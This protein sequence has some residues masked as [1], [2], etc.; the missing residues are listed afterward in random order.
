M[1]N[2]DEING[3]V[4]YNYEMSSKE[5]IDSISLSDKFQGQLGASLE[6][7]SVVIGQEDR[8]YLKSRLTFDAR[9]CILLYKRRPIICPKIFSK[10][11]KIEVFMIF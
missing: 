2:Q 4:G 9:G 3:I 1:I 8:K 7:P 10:N 5:F 6:N 11:I